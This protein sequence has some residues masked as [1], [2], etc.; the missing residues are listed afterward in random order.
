MAAERTEARRKRVK[1]LWGRP[2][3]SIAKIL[4]EEGFDVASEPK[5]RTKDAIAE[6]TAKRINAMRRNVDNDKEWWRQELRTRLKMPRSG[7]E[8]AL[9]REEHIL[10]LESDLEEIDDMLYGEGV[11]PTAKAILVGEKR[12]TRVALA[13]ARGVE[14][15]PED[16]GGEGD[17]L[18][19]RPAVL[20]YVVDND[21]STPETRAAY[22]LDGGGSES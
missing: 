3:R 9:L 4:L 8:Q 5:P 2:S 19:V 1:E 20:V 7:E 17:D 16:E 13:K 18:P 6:W 10:S 15:L 22:G 11:K 14:T 21:N 12:Q